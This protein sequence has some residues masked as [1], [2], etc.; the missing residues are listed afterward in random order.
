MNKKE[1]S[2]EFNPENE[3]IKSLEMTVQMLQREISILRNQQTNI[4]HV[5]QLDDSTVNNFLKELPH[6]NNYKSLL[7]HIIKFLTNLINF[8]ELELFIYDNQNKL[9]NPNKGEVKS[10]LEQKVYYLEEEGIINWALQSDGV[11]YIKDLTLNKNEKD[12]FLIIV[13]IK[14]NKLNKGILILSTPDSKEKLD[15]DIFEKLEQFSL[16]LSITVDNLE[17]NNQINMMNTRLLSLNSKVMQTSYIASLSGLM[18]SMIIEIQQPILIIESNIK[19]IENG[20]D[21]GKKRFDIINEQL[22]KLNEIYNSFKKL[23]SENDKELEKSVINLQ[24][25]LLDS[26]GM[27]SSQLKREGILFE[28][29]IEED[30]LLIQCYQTQL[31]QGIINIIMFLSN[32]LHDGGIINISIGST[33]RKQAFISFADNGDGLSEDEL[34]DY[35]NPESAADATSAIIEM[36]YIN[37]VI[38]INYGKILINSELN[39][40]TIIK[41]I[42]PVSS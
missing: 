7:E 16:F 8:Y 9:I 34:S 10:N 31:S 13:P 20:I 6:L 12:L 39:K 41:L 1:K 4:Q 42:F 30:N 11:S 37:K 24:D 27:I 19:L 15:D 36:Q 28:L 22:N 25:L 32:R 21:K 2:E 35:Q 18:K 23:T 17:S 38:E 3:Y 26:L 14:L 33:P 29:D 5:Q 40:G